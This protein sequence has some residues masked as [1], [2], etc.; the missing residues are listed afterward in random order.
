MLVQVASVGILAP[1]YGGAAILPEDT[2]R[3]CGD[4]P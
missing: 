1:L 2:V 3:L 4:E